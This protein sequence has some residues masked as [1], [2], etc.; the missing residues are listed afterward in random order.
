MLGSH[1]RALQMI[2]LIAAFAFMLGATALPAT[3][4]EQEEASPPGGG[5]VEEA[6]LEEIEEIVVTGIR[7]SLGQALDD[8]RNADQFLDVV[9][10]EDIGKFPDRNV[11][12]AL[13]RIP[14]VQIGRGVDVSVGDSDGIGEGS[15]VSVRG[16]R[17]EFNRATVNGQS[18]ATTSYQNGTRDFNFV[19]LSPELVRKLEVFKSPSADMDEGS[20]GAT[21]NL[22]TH[23]PMDF[24]TRKISLGARPSYSSLSN[25]AGGNYSAFWSENFGRFG[26]LLQYNYEDED[27]RRDSVESFGWKSGAYNPTTAPIASVGGNYAPGQVRAL[28]FTPENR[29]RASADGLSLVYAPQDFRQNLVLENRNRQAFNLTL[30]WRPSERWDLRLNHIESELERDQTASNNQVRFFNNN[31]LRLANARID[32][33]TISAGDFTGFNRGLFGRGAWQAVVLFDREFLYETSTTTLSADWNLDRWKLSA[34]FGITD[35]KGEQDPSLFFQLRNNG[36]TGTMGITAHYDTAQGVEKA[37]GFSTSDD[38][39]DLSL[40]TTS[41]VSRAV[42]NNEDEEDF[43][44][45]DADFDL[46]ALGFTTLEFGVKLRERTKSQLLGIDAIL[47]PDRARGRTLENYVNADSPSL[48]NSFSV[49]DT[50]PTPMEGL[51][52]ADYSTGP[53]LPDPNPSRCTADAPGPCTLANPDRGPSPDNGNRNS[54]LSNWSVEEETTAWYLKGSFESG[55]LR[56]D[57]GVRLVQTDLT[58]SN[59]EMDGTLRAREGSYSNVLPNINA[60]WNLR[61]DILLRGAIAVVISRPAFNQLTAGYNINLGAMTATTG[62]PGLDPYEATQFDLAAEW[63]FAEGAVLAGSL[64]YK[65]VDSFIE[66]RQEEQTIPGVFQSDDDTTPDVDESLELQLLAVTFPVQGRG[67]SVRGFEFAY[68]QNFLFLPGPLRHTGALFNYTYAD[69]S[70]GISDPQG[71]GLQLEGM[72]RNNSNLVLFYDDG[73]IQA[74][75]AYNYLGRYLVRTQGLGDLPVYRD[76]QGRLDLSLS[77]TFTRWPLSFSLEAINITDEPVYDYAGERNRP[78]VYRETGPRYGLS[79]RFQY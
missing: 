43:I 10:A 74:R 8:K 53:T 69:S 39:T 19:T 23:G 72:A 2:G 56:G 15:T 17:S 60:V 47:G 29:E 70:T 22:V 71:V 63:Y 21:V 9:N 28:A 36:P 76:S 30:Q 5:G 27:L 66:T 38:F 31:N 35:G 16:L 24:E 6:D 4:Q 1:G 73:S 45:L 41:G 3:A 55:K 68:Q 61:T 48:V 52:Y 33:Q 78:V 32:G 18:M 59:Y 57:I 64:F 42:R 54:W 11:A 51:V 37:P 12:E 58:S 44:Q 34:Q 77:Y 46:D 40:F 49:G 65:D 25:E 20:L 13:G 79:M 50:W 75:I 67:A 7:Q 14:G 26:F 62:D